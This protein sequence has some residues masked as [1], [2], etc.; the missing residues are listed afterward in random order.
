MYSIYGE[1]TRTRGNPIK[2]YVPTS[3]SKKGSMRREETAHKDEYVQEGLTEGTKGVC[4][5]TTRRGGSTTSFSLLG[6][7]G[8]SLLGE[9]AK[10]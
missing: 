5:T 2:R 10:D 9:A 7:A 8:L 4:S 6:F 1:A 3:K